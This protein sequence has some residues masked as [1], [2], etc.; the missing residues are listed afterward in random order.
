MWVA[1]I[2]KAGDHYY[3]EILVDH[4]WGRKFLPCSDEF[5]ELIDAIILEY[6]LSIS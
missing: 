3:L 1:T 4:H 2:E 5:E 6:G